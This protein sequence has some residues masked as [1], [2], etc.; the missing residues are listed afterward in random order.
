MAPNGRQVNLSELRDDLREPVAMLAGRLMDD[1]GDNLRSLSVVGSALTPDFHPTRSDINTVL[2][3]G[4]RS[5]D[6]LKLLARYARHM[7]RDRIAPPMLMTE[8]YVEHSLDVF[9]VG[10]LDFQFVHSTIA[11][12]D[13]FITLQFRKMDV[14]LQCERELKTMLIDLRQNY[15]RAAGDARQVGDLL[16]ESMGDLLPL[17]RAMLWL[18]GG[19]RRPEAARTVATAAQRFAFN[20]TALELPLKLRAENRSPEPGQVDV[21]FENIYRV[22]DHLSR[23]VDRMQVED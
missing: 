22:A 20:S 13:P 18:S 17:L 9:A 11:G 5:H 1:L 7:G 4:R 8:E 21:I 19:G 10:M 3:V 12:R 16:M 14:R 2:V 15:I 23:E 6:L